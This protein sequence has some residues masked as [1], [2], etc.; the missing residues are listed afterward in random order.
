MQT[1]GTVRTVPPAELKAAFR[2][3]AKPLHEA[4]KEESEA[5]RTIL[6]AVDRV[7]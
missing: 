6:A 4:A 3:A 5:V 1:P 2:E 7:R